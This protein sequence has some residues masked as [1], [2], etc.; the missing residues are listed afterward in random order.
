MTPPTFSKVPYSPVGGEIVAVND[1][2]T[3]SPEQVNDTP[4]DA[5]IFCVQADDTSALDQLLDAGAYQRMID[6]E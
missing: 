2:L 4:Y 5:W 1:S 6:A 3:D